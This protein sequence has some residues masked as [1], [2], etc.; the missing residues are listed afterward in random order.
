MPYPSAELLAVAAGGLR[1]AHN[2]TILTI[3]AL[4]REA[5]RSSQEPTQL[6]A[7]GSA[8]ERAILDKA[9]AL[10]QEP[11]P[12][13]SVWSDPPAWL[14]ADFARRSLQ[15][16]RTRDAFARDVFID[17]S[18]QTNGKRTQFGLRQGAAAA[19][20]GKSRAIR[21]IDLAVW[22]GRAVNVDDLA[23]LQRWFENE[24]RLDTTGLV[25]E[26]YL[27]R[28]PEEYHR[29]EYW[30]EDQPTNADVLDHLGAPPQNAVRGGR[31]R[32]AAEI[33]PAEAA[34]EASP[35]SGQSSV[36]RGYGWTRRL[37]DF[38]LVDADVASL[39]RRVADR[40][41]E[42]RVSFPDEQR[43]IRRCIVALLAGHLI[44]QG[45]PGTGK[46]TLARILAETFRCDLDETT[47]TSEWTPY[48]VV[49]G[50]RMTPE[51]LLPHYGHITR[52]VLQCAEVVQA[53]QS[54]ESEGQ[55]QLFDDHRPVQGVWLFID[56]FNRADIDK[57]IGSLYT[58]LG[59]SD[60]QNLAA[61]PID[62]WFE[63][64]EDRRRIW[65]PGRFRIIGAMNDVDTSYVN[66]ISQGLTRR[67]QF[68]T[69]GVSD[70][71]PSP[72]APITAEVETALAQA[73]DWI[74]RVYGS[75]LPLPNISEA[76]R[77]LRTE[78]VTLSAVVAFLRKPQGVAGWPVG[79]AQLV[80]ILRAMLLELPDGEAAESL[81]RAVADRL[82]PQ[83]GVIDDSQYEFFAGRFRAAGLNLAATELAHLIDPH[84]IA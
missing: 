60:P 13:L 40:L 6:V 61:T 3:P 57:A 16:Q 49:G 78:L 35:S 44:L 48:N 42:K 31:A 43:L 11:S 26:L 4:S 83:M 54:T 56:E 15:A 17:D 14:Q 33:Q 84:T 55:G 32:A 75:I 8:A 70:V 28:V 46:T 30:V 51:G 59:S 39:T 7:F 20:L 73:H 65:M 69:V 23:D 45:P 22:C 76:G 36:P 10:G 2:F 9:F 79:T 21:A 41:R 19:L 37:V 63:D 68:I 18:N 67:F 1:G 12:Y 64:A 81:D 80:D 72:E 71:V 29:D 25:G 74:N 24:Y 77:V 34:L 50:Y 82:I 53:Y 27:E 47:A 66:K 62:L 38:S 58:L 5:A 52:A